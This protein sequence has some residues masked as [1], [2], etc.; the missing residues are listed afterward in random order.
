MLV[1]QEQKVIDEY[2]FFYTTKGYGRMHT[3]N[4]WLTSY[5]SKKIDLFT[6]TT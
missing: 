2:T 1:K 6:T 3:L 5:P 4:A